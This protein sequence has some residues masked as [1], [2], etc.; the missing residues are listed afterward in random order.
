MSARFPVRVISRQYAKGSNEPGPTFEYIYSEP[1]RTSTPDRSTFAWWTY[2]DRSEEFNGTA[3]LGPNNIP[4][5]SAEA[6]SVPSASASSESAMHVER[7][8]DFAS[9]PDAA[10]KPKSDSTVNRWLLAIGI[11]CV[12]MGA[13]VFIRR[14]S[15]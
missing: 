1:V 3:V 8:R 14:R 13:A 9:R 5:V 11:S 15:G 12:V 7:P 6:D 4:I 10:L 2:A